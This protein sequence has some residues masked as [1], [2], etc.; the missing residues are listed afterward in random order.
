MKLFCS[1]FSGFPFNFERT[2][3]AES[4]LVRTVTRRSTESPLEF[5]ISGKRATGGCR[6]ASGADAAKVRAILYTRAWE[7][8]EV[9]VGL[10]SACAL[11]SGSINE[12]KKMRGMNQQLLILGEK[13]RMWRRRESFGLFFF[14]FCWWPVIVYV[15]RRHQSM[16]GKIRDGRR[17]L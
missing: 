2:L 6:R 7:L 16:I 17:K 15:S 13:W 8:S 1:Y 14:Y 10:K 9:G 12:L 5:L 3:L 11:L 4:S